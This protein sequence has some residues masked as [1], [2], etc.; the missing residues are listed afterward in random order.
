MLSVIQDFVSV[1]LIYLAVAAMSATI[2][3]VST[4]TLI[5]TAIKYQLFD[6]SELYRKVHKRNISRLGGVSI[7]C[8]LSLTVLLFSA[9]FGYQHP[10]IIIISSII[11]FAT[12]LKDDLY[13]IG[14]QTKL[15]LSL[16]VAILL[17][18]LG[19]FRLTSLYGVLFLGDMNYIMGGLFSIILIIFLNN[20]FNLIDGIDGL[21]GS[22]GVIINLSFGL[23][24]AS[25]GG[26][27]VAIV[28]FAMVGAL[29]GFLYYNFS[30]AKIFM[31]D[32]GSL[33]IGMVSAV[34]AIHFIELN[35]YPTLA[36]TQVKAAPAIAV[37][38]L[39]VPVFDSLLIFF[40][41]IANGRS[42]FKGDRNHIHHRIKDLDISDSK[43]VLILSVVNVICIGAAFLLNN[44]SNF[45]LIVLLLLFCFLLHVALILFENRR[46]KR[47]FRLSQ[48]I[49]KNRF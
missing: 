25:T 34:L 13:G 3:F 14:S 7:F 45:L 26:V 16:L 2:V 4:P 49:L 42:P 1:E 38:I 11:L 9:L 10:I 35:K 39:I 15:A 20:A 33:L 46:L 8:S 43:V 41:R 12:G 29:I 32:S 48:I 30:P 18:F 6:H 5:W 22:M 40:L 19:D 28:A 44:L 47:I 27:S 37:A 17:V 31:G 24:F 23:Y 21:A 36:G